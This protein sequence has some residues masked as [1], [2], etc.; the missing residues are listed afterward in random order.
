LVTT[1][2]R[3]ATAPPSLADSLQEYGRGFAGGLLFSLPLLYTMEVWWAGFL[4]GPQR[5]AGL[6]AAT[7]VVLLAYNR[8]AGLHPD[9]SWLEVAIDSVEELG[10]GIV[11]SALLLFLLGRIH[12]DMALRETL[13]KVVIEAVVVAIGFSVGT[14]Q[15]A[16]VGTTTPSRSLDPPSGSTVAGRLTV[17][18]CGALLFAG[19]VAPTE[20]IVVI[21]AETSAGRLLALALL[22]LLVAGT[23]LLLTR[24]PAHAK[25]GPSLPV[26]T[27]STY[28]VAL[29][30][31]AATLWFFG[32][33]DGARPAAAL[34]QVVALGLPAAIGAAAGRVL[35][36]VR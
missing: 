28:A 22:S 10:L 4:A 21:A 7:F 19:N 16:Q 32:R 30:V 36:A 29:L 25:A 17:G 33:F 31:G 24:R 12:P 11:T 15:L 13:G 18:F 35:L 9:A 5:L 26:D 23:I 1:A 6:V 14:A 8:V 20:E 34:R 27:C 3:K 2:K